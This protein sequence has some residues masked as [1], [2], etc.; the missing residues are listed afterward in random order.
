MNDNVVSFPVD[1]L[2]AYA[3][4]LATVAVE[5]LGPD[6]ASGVLLQAMLMVQLQYHSLDVA[7]F[8]LKRTV[9]DLEADLV[10]ALRPEGT[11]Q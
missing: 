7:V 10:K 4:A 3:E 9:A 5:N 11:V 6:D 1:S 8:C 2:D